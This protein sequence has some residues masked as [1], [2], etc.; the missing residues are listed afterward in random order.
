MPDMKT[1]D[2]ETKK[3]CYVPSGTWAYFSREELAKPENSG[4][5]IISQDLLESS[6]LMVK[7]KDSMLVA[8]IDDFHDLRG[9]REKIQKM[10]ADGAV[11]ATLL[12]QH[13]AMNI[14]AIQ[15]VLET[16]HIAVKSRPIAQ[17]DTP[18]HVCIRKNNSKRTAYARKQPYINLLHSLDLPEAYELEQ[19]KIA[20][21]LDY[22]DPK[23]REHLS[24]L[25]SSPEIQKAFS[26][27]KGQ[28]PDSKATLYNTY[29]K[30][31]IAFHVG[32]DIVADVL[33]REFPGLPEL[34]SD[35]IQTLLKSD[36]KL[37]P[38]E[39]KKYVMSA[40]IFPSPTKP[41]ELWGT[42]SSTKFKHEAGQAAY[43]AE[44]TSRKERALKWAEF[45]SPLSPPYQ[46]NIDSVRTATPPPAEEDRKS[47]VA[48]ETALKTKVKL[49]D[50]ERLRP[51]T[52]KEKEIREQRWHQEGCHADDKRSVSDR[53]SSD[54]NSQE[55]SKSFVT[56]TQ[57]HKADRPAASR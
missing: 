48:S 24:A 47:W 32:E 19:H 46:C 3:V 14:L 15:S 26:T 52:M 56:I 44:N 2:I 8:H 50:P 51:L 10:K 36:I 28:Q 17:S 9:L 18:F 6:F 16:E 11:Q 35:K 20:L 27:W 45:I 23:S 1:T 41:E 54:T 5:E 22:N 13:R 12:S 29:F 37:S 34:I 38:L 7:N 25:D 30:L 21:Y 53:F 49:A 31:L 39:E 43:A 4:L 33:Y 57:D 55:G 40:D 42:F